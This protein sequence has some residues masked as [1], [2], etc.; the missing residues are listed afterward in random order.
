M[1][2][3]Y[4][5][6]KP[7]DN[8]KPFTEE[9][10]GRDFTK[11]TEEEIH[12]VLDELEDWLLEEKPI[13]ND[14]KEVVTYVDKGNVFYRDFLFKKKLFSD[15]ITYVQ[16]QYST[17]SKR[18]Q[19]ID[20][21]QE[22]KL[23]KLAFEGKGKENITKFILTNKYDWREKADTKVDQTLTQINWVEEKTYDEPT[24]TK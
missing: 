22:H 14:K 20:S 8:P 21:I 7:S 5:N 11:W 13:L 4:K 10:N 15:W 17:V 23:Q 1:P 6:I 16:G 3:G 2:G 19:Y 24:D 12:K 9:Y 18:F